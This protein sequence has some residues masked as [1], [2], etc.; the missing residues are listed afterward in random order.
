MNSPWQSFLE[1]LWPSRSGPSNDRSYR[2]ILL[3]SLVALGIALAAG[4]EVFL[5][6]EMTAVMELLGVGLFL[7]AY[8]S[9]VQLLATRLARGIGMLMVPAG[10]RPLVHSSAPL[11]VRVYA[12]LLI[13]V[14][15]TGW[16][17]LAAAF[18]A[19]IRITARM[20]A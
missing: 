18:G 12:C 10:Q 8:G 17:A 3:Q 6:A 5:A 15:V 16:I 19:W 20:V 9:A 2:L 4:P 11:Q 7:M 1:Y 14:H 13:G